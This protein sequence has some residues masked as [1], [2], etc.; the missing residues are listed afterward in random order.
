MSQI[1]KDGT[2]NLFQIP[3]L[4]SDCGSWIVVSRDTGE[5]IMET[6]SQRVAEA[7][8]QNKYEVLTARQWLVRFNRKILPLV[9]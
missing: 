5:P 2:D 6:F 9:E 4:E 1:L 8:D 3:C 7:I